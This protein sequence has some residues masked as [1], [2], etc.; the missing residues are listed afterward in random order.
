[1]CAPRSSR[2]SCWSRA[3]ARLD[4]WAR[5]A[6]SARRVLSGAAL[7][8]SAVTAGFFLLHRQLGT[9]GVYALYVWPGIVTTLLLV[10]F[11]E[12]LGERFTITQA[13]RLYGL[14][15]AGGVASSTLFA[16]LIRGVRAHRRE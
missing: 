10:H 13:K 5:R 4:A 7:G 14:I 2:C 3:T 12:L 15:G 11:W 1:M 16:H 9:A 8:A 6:R